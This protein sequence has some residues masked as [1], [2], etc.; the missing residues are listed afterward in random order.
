MTYLFD[1]RKSIPKMAGICNDSTTMTDK[2]QSVRI[3]PA[4]CSDDPSTPTCTVQLAYPPV[5]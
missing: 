5:L 3:V 4:T 2:L 1:S